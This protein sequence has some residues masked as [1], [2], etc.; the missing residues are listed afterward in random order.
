MELELIFASARTATVLIKDGGLYHTL[1][2]YQ[3][4]LNG[5][6]YGETEKTTTSLFGL[7]PDTEYQLEVLDGEEVLGS[8][9]LRTKAE[10]CTLNVRRFGA[11]GDG[12]HDDTTAIQTA[13]LCCPDQ[14]RVLIPAGHYRVTPLFLKS[15]VTVE[16]QKGAILQL[17]TD[18]TRFPILPGMVQSTDETDDYNFGTWEGNPLDMFAAAI[19]GVNVE[20]AV[21]CGE[22]TID[23][24]A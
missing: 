2:P 10:S 24:Q 6:P 7:W 3:L 12:L 9:H 21:L 16:L 23:G 15:H 11:V 1:K 22:G 14:G 17:D 8:I 19:T 4:R 18:R 13:I 20:D 5:K